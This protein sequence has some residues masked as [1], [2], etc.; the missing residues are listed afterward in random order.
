M[1]QSTSMIIL[2]VII[3]AVALFGRCTDTKIHQSATTILEDR[4]KPGPLLSHRF[5]YYG[6][7]IEGAFSTNIV[8][9]DTLF[10][11]NN[12]YANDLRNDISNLPVESFKVKTLRSDKAAGIG[13]YG[14]IPPQYTVLSAAATLNLQPSVDEYAVTGAGTLSTLAGGHHGRR[15]TIV[16]VNGQT[17]S[18]AGNFVLA[19]NYSAA[20]GQHVTFYYDAGYAKWAV[21]PAQP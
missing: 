21:F 20:S 8:N 11:Q 7:Y 17:I 15:V 10:T 5:D 9:I 19:A 14:N 1:K 3:L 13:L 6:T 4:L 12:T 16:F 2:T 18:S